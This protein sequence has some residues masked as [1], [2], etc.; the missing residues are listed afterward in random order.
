MNVHLQP[1]LEVF[2]KLSVVRVDP[3]NLDQANLLFRMYAFR[4][5]YYCVQNP[6]VKEPFSNLRLEIDPFDPFVLYH[7]GVMNEAGEIVAYQRIIRGDRP[8]MFEYAAYNGVEE[9]AKV[10]KSANTAE[11]SRLAVDHRLEGASVAH[12]CRGLNLVNLIYRELYRIC[13]EQNIEEIYFATTA[14]TIRKGKTRGFP[15]ELTRDSRLDSGETIQ[16][17]RL[18]WKEFEQVNALKRPDL[19]EWYQEPEVK[20]QLFLVAEQR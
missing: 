6:W 13:Q 19:L 10:V 17:V 20:D 7:Y 18:N 8:W 14:P 11:I 16:L 9:G 2:M 1:S 4:Y 3:T 15:L 12:R 5:R